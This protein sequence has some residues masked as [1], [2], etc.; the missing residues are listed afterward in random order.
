MS[1]PDLS[2]RAPV[3][4]FDLYVDDELGSVWPCTACLPWHFDVIREGDDIYVREWHAAECPTL[5]HVLAA[6]H[7]S[8]GG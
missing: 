3:A 8:D 4:F 7:R 2:Y 1:R 5:A 6:I